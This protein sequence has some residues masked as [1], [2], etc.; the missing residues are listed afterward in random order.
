MGKSK[1]DELAMVELPDIE[2]FKG[3]RLAPQEV[4]FIMNYLS[5]TCGF[6]SSK[7]YR[8]TIGEDEFKA[9][10]KSSFYAK[11]R[12]MMSKD[13]V[14]TAISRLLTR[15]VE[16]RKNEI[17]PMLINDLMLAASYDPAQI[18]DDDGDL[19]GG[20][21]SDIP[22]K[23]RRA[24]IEGISVKYWGKD[25]DV[26][27]REVKLASKSKAR[28]DLANIVKLLN[29]ISDGSGNGDTFNVT[30]ST[31]NIPG[32]LTA[33]ELLQKS[34]MGVAEEVEEE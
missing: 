25:C 2:E 6:D 10:A 26:R 20:S 32:M 9:M 15:E 11:A 14:K 23:Y 7:A 18:I 28:S 19:L 17:V 31:Q 33:Q 24:V 27:T 13:D 12:S 5:P 29:N 34:V 8:M 30:I 16:E 3:L 1:T 22:A 21:L 4:R